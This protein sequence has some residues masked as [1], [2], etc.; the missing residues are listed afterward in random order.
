ME[1]QN[2]ERL[3]AFTMRFFKRQ[4]CPLSTLLFNII[5]EVLACAIRQEKNK[6]YTDWKKEIKLYLFT[7]NM[8]LY[9]E[10]AKESIKKFLEIINEF[11]KV[12]RY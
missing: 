12:A 4:K 3:V 10:D 5:L 11:R 1:P 2:S 9:M 6:M 8:F 7:D